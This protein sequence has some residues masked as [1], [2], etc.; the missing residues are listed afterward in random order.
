MTFRRAGASPEREIE[1][2][3]QEVRELTDEVRV[4]SGLARTDPLTGLAN[5]R[6]WDEHLARELARARRR[7][8]P[9]AVALMDLDDFKLL[10]DVHGHQEGD[11]VL[12]AAATGWL[13]QLREADLL[14]RWGGDEFAV[15]LPNCPAG[16]ADVV[17]ARLVAATPRGQA[18]SAG[19]A[20]W[21]GEESAEALLARV[22]RALYERKLELVA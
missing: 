11:R 6:A 3:T 1:A 21:D 19:V 10:N 14:C 20:A 18:C 9:L 7:H 13:G 22:D 17:V 16:E 2:L 8:E 15:L 5:R 12:V 4:L